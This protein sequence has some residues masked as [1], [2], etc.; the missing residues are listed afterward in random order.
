MAYKF[1]EVGEE[2]DEG[3]AVNL[4]NLPVGTACEMSD[5]KREQCF[6]QPPPRYSEASLVKALEQNGVSN[7][8]RGT[9]LS[10]LVW[11]KFG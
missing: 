1:R 3:T 4:P 8:S 9:S 6:S 10:L 5:L 2:E 7:C 11:E